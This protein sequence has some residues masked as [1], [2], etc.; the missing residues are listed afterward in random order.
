MSSPTAKNALRVLLFLLLALAA[1]VA[2]ARRAFTPPRYPWH[3]VDLW[4][5]SAASTPTFSELAI[6]FEIVGEVPD[7]VDL[8]IAPL[9]LVQVGKIPAY[10]GVQTAI[11]GWPGKKDRRM[12][13]IGR[14]GI[15]SRWSVDGEPVS[16]DEAT[17]PAGTHYEAADYE[18]EF[19]SVR[20]HVAW[21]SGR[22]TYFLRRSKMSGG[23]WLK[24][25]V[26]EL[27]SGQETEIGSLRFD[28]S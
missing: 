7:G 11:R 24:A 6:D 20:R 22:Y 23:L 17:G 4:W 27:A 12:L 8:Y 5:T 26:R 25:S 3:L 18:D 1:Q 14:G 16:L 2:L 15:F 21:K 13:P 10:G 19:V 9:G 28:A